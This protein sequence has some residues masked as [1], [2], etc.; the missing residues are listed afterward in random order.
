[1]RPKKHETT[2]SGDL[3]RARLDQIINFK[4]ELVLAGQIDW[5]FCDRA[6]AAQAHLRSVR[7]RCLTDDFAP[8]ETLRAIEQNN[9]NN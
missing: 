1:M 4:H 2:G 8:V 9:D 5:D 6:A 3:F 7:R